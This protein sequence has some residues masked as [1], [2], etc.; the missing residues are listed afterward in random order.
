MK[1]KIMILVF[2]SLIAPMILSADLPVLFDCNRFLSEENNTIFEISYKIYHK[3]LRFRLFENRLCA[4]LDIKFSIYNKVGKELYAKDYSQLISGE[5]GKTTIEPE[6]FFIDKIIAQV[7]PGIYEFAIE[8]SDRLSKNKILWD[9]KLKTLDTENLIISDL[10]INSFYKSDTTESFTNFKR[11]NIIFLVNPNHLINPSENPSFA[12][13]FEVY[14]LDT[15]DSKTANWKIKIFSSKGSTAGRENDSICYQKSQEFPVEHDRA[16]FWGS[17]SISNWNPGTYKIVVDV[18]GNVSTQEIF[19][20]SEPEEK[21]TEADV[22]AEYRY[23]RYFL[24]SQDNKIYQ[25]L[26]NKAKLEFIERF[27]RQNDPNPITEKN[28][29]KEEVIRRTQY[30]DEHFAHFKDGWKTDR[31]RIYIRRGKPAEIIEKGYEFKAKPYIIWKYYQD[32]K[33]IYIFVDFTG[34]SNYKLVYSENDEKEFT[35][36]NWLDYMGEYFDERELE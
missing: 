13:Y 11:D 22:E 35:D 16:A 15:I 6:G 36:P 25:D 9:K 17:I 29:F 27:W 3:N 33:R 14:N 4:Q 21:V 7:T 32:G 30:A 10:E 5:A 1:N 8:I 19:F 24:T 18:P 31:G 2:V 12:Y 26:S 34:Q 20:I 23:V 28:E